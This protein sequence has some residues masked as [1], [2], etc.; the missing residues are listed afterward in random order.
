MTTR[1]SMGR[2]PTKNGEEMTMVLY[3]RFV[4]RA[5]RSRRVKDA[6]TATRRRERRAARQRGWTE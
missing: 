3:R 4:A 6:K 5:G 2:R 1:P